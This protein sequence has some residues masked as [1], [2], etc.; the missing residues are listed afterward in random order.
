MGKGDSVAILLPL[1]GQMHGQSES[2]RVSSLQRL[3]V[4][5]GLP[6][7][8]RIVTA[9]NTLQVEC[10]IREHQIEDDHVRASFVERWITKPYER[11]YTISRR[12]VSDGHW[13][14]L[15][16]NEKAVLWA[17]ASMMRTRDVESY[18]NRAC[19]VFSKR[20]PR[21]ENRCSKT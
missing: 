5:A 3:R 13:A 16:K 7:V 18:M 8:A 21:V 20:C 11:G 6:N 10:V 2:L 1:L 14:A 15:R 17:I 9:L 4:Q 12:L 19:S